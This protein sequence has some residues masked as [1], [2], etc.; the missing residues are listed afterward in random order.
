MR[1]MLLYLKILPP[2]VDSIILRNFRLEDRHGRESGGKLGQRL[3]TTAADADQQSMA[4]G[5]AQNTSDPRQ[6][7]QHV[8]M[9]SH[10]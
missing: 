5:N 4:A 7:L 1:I 10:F 9:T 3:S 2:L 8:P 6:V